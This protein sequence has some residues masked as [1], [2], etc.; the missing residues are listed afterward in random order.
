MTSNIDPALLI[1]CANA[2]KVLAHPARLRIAE[3]LESRR[4]TVG[5]L[6]AALRVPQAVAS[7][8]LTRMKAAGLLVVER[9]GRKSFY[10]VN[11]PSCFAVLDCIRAR[12]SKKRGVK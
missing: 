8:H 1:H 11:D 5:E 3:I 6:A 7:Q 4:C 9:E 10:R 2:L 12:T